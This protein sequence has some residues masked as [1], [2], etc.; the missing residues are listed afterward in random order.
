MSADV[1]RRRTAA[2]GRLLPAWG[3]FAPDWR[4]RLAGRI[5]AACASSSVRDDETAAQAALDA[6]VA[7]WAAA[8]A[9]GG[10]PIPPAALRA[11]FLAIDGAGRW[12]DQFLEVRPDGAFLEAL[13]GALP[14]PLPSPAPLDMPEQPL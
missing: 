11:A 14:Q 7:R 12:P 10:E 6:L 5:A 13:R 2:A 8:L 1:A 3:A 4:Q 9:G